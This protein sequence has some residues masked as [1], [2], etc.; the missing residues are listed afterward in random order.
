MYNQEFSVYGPLGRARKRFCHN[1]V[2]FCLLYYII[3]IHIYIL[4]T[5]DHDAE[6][7]DN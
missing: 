3:F 4:L 5:N 2:S 1:S 6:Y 7:R